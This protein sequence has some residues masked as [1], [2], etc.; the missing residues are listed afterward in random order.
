MRIL[1]DIYRLWYHSLFISCWTAFFSNLPV[2]VDVYPL[3]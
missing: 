1:K 2:M 3:Y